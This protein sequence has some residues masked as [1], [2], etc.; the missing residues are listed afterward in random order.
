MTN[1]AI[2]PHWLWVFP[3]FFAGIWF[4]TTTMLGVMSGWYFLAWRFRDR[5]EV[6]IFKLTG[7]S[8]VVGLV[9]A[10][11]ILRLS[12]C[13]SGLRVGILW[14]FGPFCRDF[15]VP[16]PEITV[17]RRNRILWKSAELKFGRPSA[18]R[19]VLA[20]H[21]ADQ[22]AR[23]AGDLWPE[24]GSFPPETAG[25]RFRRIMVESLLPLAVLPVF[26]GV[27]MHLPSFRADMHMSEGQVIQ[28]IAII[29]LGYAIM[30]G[31]MGLIRFLVSLLVGGGHK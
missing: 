24:T 4:L 26:L 2:D 19:L 15:L 22:L 9:G 21:V 6:A 16:W 28:L 8:G 31:I 1:Q 10:S 20:S 13:P 14:L 18:G 7:Q 29:T 17:R 27:V 11:N 23:A 30:F 3:L 25:R 5:P 12:V